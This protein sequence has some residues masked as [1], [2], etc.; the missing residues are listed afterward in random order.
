MAYIELSKNEILKDY[1][2]PFFVAELNTSHFG[3][4]D[5]A[6]KMIFEAKKAGCDC[7]KFQSWSEDSL[8][9]KDYYKENPIAKRFFK[10]F[11]LSPTELSNLIRYCKNIGIRF[12]STPYSKSEVD[13]LAEE[14]EVPFIKVASMDLNN[15]PFLE[16]I[17][18]SGK[19]VVLSTGMGSIDEVEQAVEL[20]E[21]SGASKICILHCVAVYPPEIETLQLNNILGLRKKFDKHPIGYSDHSI[22]VEMACA[23]VTLGACLIEKHFTLDKSKLGMD[24]QMATEPAEMKN[25]IE[26]CKNI[27]A[28]LGSQDRMLSNSELDQRKKMRRSIVSARAIKKGDVI[29]R[30]DVDF[31]RPGIGISPADIKSLIG[32]RAAKNFEFDEIILRDDII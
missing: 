28:A 15:H 7:V 19:P 11:S 12:A 21:N 18:S 23:A 27:Y 24:N 3:D 31:K 6:R 14:S 1:G 22:G 4:M 16:Y 20:L 8:Y 32:K 26:S 2:M 30:N 17:G 13:I 25:L 29:T 9:T 5:I 10:K